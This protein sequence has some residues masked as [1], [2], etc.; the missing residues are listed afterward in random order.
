MAVQTIVKGLR[1]P[2]PAVIAE[3]AQDHVTETGLPLIHDGNRPEI[4]ER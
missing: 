4:K 1:Q 2:S 3:V